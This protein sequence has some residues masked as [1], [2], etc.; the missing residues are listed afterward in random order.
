MTTKFTRN[1]RGETTLSVMLGAAIGAI[2]IGGFMAFFL[3]ANGTATQ[4]AEHAS[5]Q[6]GFVQAA[7]RIGRDVQE[8]ERFV[9]VSPDVL[10]VDSGTTWTRWSVDADGVLV[11]Q[12]A[13][14]GTTDW[15]DVSAQTVARN[16]AANVFAANPNPSYGGR[17]VDITL[18]STSGG[19]EIASSATLQT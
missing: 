11:S 15:S 17:L 12:H 14:E 6:T 10:V 16:V 1:E 3:T 7:N 13:A 8:A 9:A 5:T 4:S 18:S 19:E 2:I